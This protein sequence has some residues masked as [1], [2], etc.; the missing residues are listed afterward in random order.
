MNTKVSNS[1][2][3]I[4]FVTL[5]NKSFCI[6]NSNNVGSDLTIISDL[7]K[8]RHFNKF[9]KNTSNNNNNNSDKQRDIHENYLI[10]DYLSDGE[11]ERRFNY[12]GIIGKETSIGNT[13]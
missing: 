12:N 6:N 10:V 2:L 1:V 3:M 11:M 5:V 8:L 13:R 9:I 4:I 7:P